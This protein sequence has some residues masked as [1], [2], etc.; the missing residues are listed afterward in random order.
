[1]VACSGGLKAVLGAIMGL[2]LSGEGETTLGE[3]RKF[4]LGLARAGQG[5]SRRDG[6]TSKRHDSKIS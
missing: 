5:V 3:S 4:T 2:I 1:M 6:G